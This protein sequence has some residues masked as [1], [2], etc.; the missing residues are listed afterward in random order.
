MAALSA[1]ITP[2][3]SQFFAWLLSRRM[4]ADSM[5]M[6]ASTLVD[7]QVAAKDC[8]V[9]LNAIAITQMRSLVGMDALKQLAGSGTHK[10]TTK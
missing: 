1:D 10:R 6:L 8:L 2:Y 5:G 3:Q 4:A 9:Q 7:A